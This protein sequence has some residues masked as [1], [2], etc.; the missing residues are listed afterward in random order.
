MIVPSL[1]RLSMRIKERSVPTKYIYVFFLLLAVVIGLVSWTSSLDLPPNFSRYN[2]YVIFKQAF[3]HLIHYQDLYINYPDK[4]YDLFKYSPT[5]AL[6]MGLFANL[7]DWLGLICF[8]LVNIIVLILGIR[9]LPL[10]KKQLNIFLAFIVVETLISLTSSQT[11]ILITGLLILAWHYM[12]KGKMWWAALMIVLTVYIKIFGIVAMSLFLLYPKKGQAALATIC[13][14]ILVGLLPLCVVSP[15]QLGILYKSWAGLLTVD[16]DSSVGISF[17]G[18][19]NKWFGFNFHKQLFVLIGAAIFCIPLFRYKAWKNPEYRLGILASILLWVVIF[20]HKGESP[21]YVIA[22][23]GAGIWY[24]T[25]AHRTK[26]D[27][28]LLL[29]ALV[30]TS[31]S[32][33]DVITPYWIAQKYVE[34]YSIKAVFCTLIWFKL[35]YDLTFEP[36]GS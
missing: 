1:Q 29:L 4:H 23:V 28:V 22:I 18:W 2:N 7:P 26:T 30:F 12:D 11:N 31:F 10:E 8:N 35:I 34:P 16:H 6:W 32:S 27:L 14:T 15:E 36:K 21:T 25:K 20:N 33:T 19:L 3:F 13:W 9:T 24:F 17:Y 5:F